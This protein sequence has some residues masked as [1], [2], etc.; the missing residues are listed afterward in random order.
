VVGV[1]REPTTPVQIFFLLL[2]L[3]W[4]KASSQS[5]L[6]REYAKG[7]PLRVV[8]IDGDTLASLMIEHAVGV[9]PDASYEIKRVDSD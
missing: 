6:P 3:A 5:G 8:L 2:C 4:R 1:V 7:L 9:T